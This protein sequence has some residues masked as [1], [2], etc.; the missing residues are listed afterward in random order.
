MK[1]M[2][3]VKNSNHALHRPN[4]EF[5]NMQVKPYQEV[6]ERIG[7]IEKVFQSSD[8]SHEFIEAKKMDESVL[9]K[10]HTKALIEQIKQISKESNEG[11]Y[12]MPYVFPSKIVSDKQTNRI[13]RCNAHCMDMGTPVGKHTFDQALMSCS[14]AYDC[15]N[16]ILEGDKL[17]YGLCR[18]P[19]HHAETNTYG[20]YCYFNNAGIAANR[21]IEHGKV[22]VLDID[23]H[24][25]NGTQELFYDKDS[26]LYVSIHGDPLTEYPYYT[27]FSDETGTGKG[28]GYNLNFPLPQ[29]VTEGKYINTLNV[30]L[31]KISSYKPEFLIISLGL[32]TYKNDPICKFNLDLDSYKT[33]GDM[34]SRLN[35]P[36]IVLQEGGYYSEDLG[37][38]AL[39]FFKGI[40]GCI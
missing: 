37:Y 7:Y 10:I 14:I 12:S 13:K 18:P 17:I 20:G 33:V 34:I 31:D 35:L 36:T 8:F 28:L 9:H 5:D 22:C 15:S 3:I 27:G 23:Y 39:N 30:A 1:R 26:V 25:G 29:G 6:P 21:L 16:F 40:S 24:H 2:K 4:A 38:L 32:D 19:G 11:E